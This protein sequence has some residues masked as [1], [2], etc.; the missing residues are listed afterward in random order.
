[1]LSIGETVLDGQQLEVHA[2][3]HGQLSFYPPEISS[4]LVSEVKHD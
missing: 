1:M 4:G 3:K 2:I